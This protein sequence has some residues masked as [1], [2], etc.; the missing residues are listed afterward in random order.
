VTLGSFLLTLSILSSIV[1]DFHSH[2]SHFN[3]F[4]TS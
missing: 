3:H 1:E 2:S 4:S